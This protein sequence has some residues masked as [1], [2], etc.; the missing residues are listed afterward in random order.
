MKI[1]QFF[2]GGRIEDKSK[3]KVVMMQ[4]EGK[5][6]QWHQH[7]TRTN[8]GIIA[9]SWTPYI[10]EIRKRFG[11]IEFSNPMFDIVVFKQQ[12]SMKD[13][14]KAFLSLLNFLQLSSKYAL[15]IFISNLKPE[16]SH[17]IRLF[18]LKTL[19]HAFM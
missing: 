13:Y 9:L 16:I 19:S 10:K 14:Y 6:L 8:E 5:A 18:F 4:L 2:K 3:I 11:D 15:S 12:G 7:Y 1:D 17:T